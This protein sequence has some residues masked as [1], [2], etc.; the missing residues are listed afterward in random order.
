MTQSLHHSTLSLWRSRNRRPLLPALLTLFFILFPTATVA[1][2]TDT[3]FAPYIRTSKGQLETS[4]IRLKNSKGH[5]LDLISAVHVGSADYY[6]TLNTKF[7]GYDSVLYEL[8][9]P[10]EVA[11]Q[12]LP[13]QLETGSGL[14]SIQ[15]MLAGALGLTTQ[16]QRIDYSPNNFVHAD[17]TQSGLSR[18]MAERNEDILTYLM[19]AL[20][21][22]K[23]TTPASLGI[24]EQE[25]A[26]VDFMALLSGQAKPKDQQ[27]MRKVFASALSSSGGLMAGMEDSALVAERNIRAL[28]V[29]NTELSGSKKKVAIF[30]GAAHMP[31]FARRLRKAGWSV[32]DTD[33]IRAW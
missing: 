1:D 5:T 13:A 12:R 28:Q 25:L 11:G 3:G 30:Y 32:V 17:L 24:S 26:Q 27:I 14:S 2:Q 18:K 22:S 8:V 21:A 29:L 7:K 33:W 20:Q 16:L 4:V 10:D 23:S 15:Q 9:L 6:K 31:D 19:R